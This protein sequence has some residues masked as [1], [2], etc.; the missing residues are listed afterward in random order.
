[1]D[2]I[3]KTF[4][5]LNTTELYAI[6][7]LRSAVFVVEQNCAYQDIDELDQRSLHVLLLEDKKTIAYSRLL[8]P[9]LVY[10]EAA[11]GRVVVD[12]DF[13]K[14]DLGK[15]LMQ[16]SIRKILELFDSHSIVISAQKYLL[17]F[18]T[19]LGFVTQG[20]EYLEDDIPHIKMKYNSEVL[21]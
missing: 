13:R 6:L 15:K 14:K 9:G 17:K 21:R 1:M 20:E 18:Y 12:P 5:E 10:K 8:P 19:E 2:F 4:E 3:L 16:Y 11:I 7:K